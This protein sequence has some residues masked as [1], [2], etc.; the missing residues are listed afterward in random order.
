M[1]DWLRLV[2]ISRNLFLDKKASNHFYEDN[3]PLPPKDEGARSSGYLLDGFVVPDSDFDEAEHSDASNAARKRSSIKDDAE[4]EEVEAPIPTTLPSINPII[5]SS[6]ADEH[7]DG[8]EL[9]VTALPVMDL[10][11]QDPLMQ[12]AYAQ[13]PLINPF[14]LHFYL[15]LSEI[16]YMSDENLGSLFRALLFVKHGF[17]INMA[18]V[19]L[20]ILASSFRRITL[21]QGGAYANCVMNGVVSS[22]DLVGPGVLAGS[23]NLESE[24]F[25]Q[26][27]ISIFP[28]RQ[29][30]IRD[31]GAIFQV[32]QLPSTGVKGTYSKGGFAFVTRAAM[33]YGL[34]LAA[35]YAVPK[36]LPGPDLA[37]HSDLFAVDAVPVATS[38]ASSYATK[39][40]LEYDDVGIANLRWSFRDRP[41]FPFRPPG[42]QRSSN[43]EALHAKPVQLA[44]P[45]G[46]QCWLLSQ[47]VHT[48]PRRVE[49]AAPLL[50]GGLVVRER[51]GP[52]IVLYYHLVFAMCQ[53]KI[54]YP[55]TTNDICR[56]NDLPALLGRDSPTYV[57]ASKLMELEMKNTPVIKEDQYSLF[58]EQMHGRPVTCATAG[59]AMESL[60]ATLM[61]YR[62]IDLDLSTR[63]SHPRILSSSPSLPLVTKRT[64]VPFEDLNDL[65]KIIGRSNKDL[66]HRDK[67]LVKRKNPL[68]PTPSSSALSSSNPLMSL[69]THFAKSV[70]R[71]RLTNTIINLSAA[72]LHLAYLLRGNVYLPTETSEIEEFLISS[73]DDREQMDRIRTEYGTASQGCVPVM[74]RTLFLALTVSPVMLLMPRSYEQFAGKAALLETWSQFGSIVRPSSIVSADTAVWK[75][76]F[77]ATKGG[78]ILADLKVALS[79]LEPALGPHSSP[80]FA[81]TPH[82]PVPH[83]STSQTSMVVELGSESDDGPDVGIGP[84]DESHYS[85]LGT[86]PVSSQT[87]SVQTSTLTS[88]PANIT[89]TNDSAIDPPS[90]DQAL[91]PPLLRGSEGS[92][93]FQDPVTVPDGF[94]TPRLAGSDPDGH[95]MSD[96]TDLQSPAPSPHSASEPL[97]AIAQHELRGVSPNSPLHADNTTVVTVSG[98]GPPPTPASQS[99]DADTGCIDPAVLQTQSPSPV[100]APKAPL[101]FERP[102]TRSTAAN[103]PSVTKPPSS[104]G[105][106]KTL[107]RPT[108]T[109]T[110]KM[111]S[112]S[113]RKNSRKRPTKKVKKEATTTVPDVP[114]EPIFIDLTLEGSDNDLPDPPIEVNSETGFVTGALDVT[115]PLAGSGVPYTWKPRFHLRKYKKQQALYDKHKASLKIPWNKNSVKVDGRGIKTKNIIKFVKREVV[116]ALGS[117]PVLVQEKVCEIVSRL[118]EREIHGYGAASDW[119]ATV[120]DVVGTKGGSRERRMEDHRDLDERI[121]H[122]AQRDERRAKPTRCASRI[123]PSRRRLPQPTVRPPTTIVWLFGKSLPHVIIRLSGK[124]PFRNRSVR[125]RVPGSF[126]NL[127]ELARTFDNSRAPSTTRTHLPQRYDSLIP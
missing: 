72:A 52:E 64:K 127:K 86:K 110:P 100:M 105:Q 124:G 67:E 6:S 15:N 62:L 3:G 46:H 93:E 103:N 60:Y 32:L 98:G 58:V 118:G 121:K 31:I 95:M 56:V 109:S 69:Y 43:L 75:V 54:S 104:S 23:S 114:G 28:F 120:V 41:A 116:R 25:L 27:R 39:A 91:I 51:P 5:G 102:V 125:T 87:V 9:D 65:K 106:K 11:L 68:D 117:V 36:E 78:D 20:S 66:Q 21:K 111:P 45:F 59:Q 83:A 16:N 92:Q 35:G 14:K 108:T 122:Q 24:K 73:S 112:Q 2:R 61:A 48:P 49:E 57:L 85:A 96:R 74:Q 29:E 4:N 34:D 10:D 33:S 90:C 26:H 101:K 50:V 81:V 47:L 1:R 42:F 17:Y 79:E 30:I 18:R 76:L 38:V 94:T 63:G 8:V 84:S 126:K 113:G 80:W 115:Y 70:Q 82:K 88:S 71:H 22:C 12:G 7:E 97:T 13:L 123:L 89:P 37:A 40:V 44:S 53:S 55:W 107:K 119:N 19:D 77:S 99:R